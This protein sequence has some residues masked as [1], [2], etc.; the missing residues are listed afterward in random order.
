MDGWMEI[1]KKGRG[2]QFVFIASPNLSTDLCM[3]IAIFSKRNNGKATQKDA[4]FK[5]LVQFFTVAHV[6][7]PSVLV[8]HCRFELWTLCLTLCISEPLNPPPK[9]KISEKYK[10][11]TKREKQPS[12]SGL[13][14]ANTGLKW[15]NTFLWKSNSS[16]NLILCLCFACLL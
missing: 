3:W 4:C 10:H 16:T 1:M 12:S 2:Y 6:F 8:L 5:K 11:W 13:L 15:W 14:P 9:K 7:E